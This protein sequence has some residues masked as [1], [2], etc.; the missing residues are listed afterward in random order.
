[1]NE[2]IIGFECM[3]LGNINLSL[4]NLF[5]GIDLSSYKY[6]VPDGAYII[7]YRPN[8][9]QNIPS[10]CSNKFYHNLCNT[11]CVEHMILH[12]FPY[13]A[14]VTS[15]PT[16]YAYVKSE[17]Q[18]VVLYYDYYFLEVYAKNSHVLERLVQNMRDI[19]ATNITFKTEA[20]DGRTE[21]YV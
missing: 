9:M 8:D 21:F 1:M 15:V 11:K 10:N 19:G 13:D 7:G 4:D 12:I 20:N 14:A 2:N 3:L 5:L 6:V 16:Y 17:C 18:I